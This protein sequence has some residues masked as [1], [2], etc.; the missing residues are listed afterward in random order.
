MR[1]LLL[2]LFGLATSPFIG[3]GWGDTVWHRFVAD[4][5][6]W[7]MRL[8][9]PQSDGV[10]EVNGCLMASRT[11]KGRAID[12]LTR[13][14]V[15]DGAY[16]P[17]MT[18]VFGELLSE[19]MVV[20]DVGANVGYYTLLAARCVGERG[21]VWAF[22]PEPQNFLEL[23]YNIELNKFG[24]IVAAQCKAV[25]DATGST[26][27]FVSSVE[28][29]EHSLVPCRDRNKATIDVELARL[30]D[31]ITGHVDVLKTDTEG[32]DMRVLMGAMGLLECNRD[33]KLFTEFWP[34]GLEAAG[35]SARQYWDFLKGLGF[36]I[37]LLD[38]SELLEAG[39]KDVIAHIGGRDGFSANLLCWRGEAK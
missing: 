5:Y 16:E 10:I 8:V 30:D 22:E 17:S 23:Q 37:W 35:L 20:V 39:F 25:S 9:V 3:K 24:H 29:G 6:R 26:K 2:R 21:R 4:V 38:G 15:I 34:K 13:R 36:R 18:K 32:N 28:S 1:R 33:M 19:G 27:L 31:I 7:V 12:G 11:G 14:L